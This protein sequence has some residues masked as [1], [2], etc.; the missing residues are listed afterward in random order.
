MP[1]VPCV[2]AVHVVLRC[3]MPASLE[4]SRLLCPAVLCCLVCPLPCALCCAA[5]HS[6][7]PQMF[8][9]QVMSAYQYLSPG[10]IFHKETS[11]TYDAD[12]QRFQSFANTPCEGVHVL[13]GATHVAV[14]FA[15]LGELAAAVC[16][17]GTTESGQLAAYP[18][19][20]DQGRPDAAAMQADVAASIQRFEQVA[21]ADGNSA[22]YDQRDL[23]ANNAHALLQ[24]LRGV[25]QVHAGSIPSTS[26]SNGDGSSWQQPVMSVPGQEGQPLR[27]VGYDASP[28]AVAKTAVLLEMMTQ[29][30]DTDAVLQVS[31]RLQCAAVCLEC[32]VAQDGSMLSIT[33]VVSC[34]AVHKR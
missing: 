5:C 12:Q 23:E 34:N 6:A 17:W 13:P 10:K 26:S 30:A 9:E 31:C 2:P 20:F 33:A 14:G 11:I 25:Q 32:Y 1:A 8:D 18:L 7:L 21:A 22:P 3:H 4:L 27:W 16:R 28:Y 29:N 15:D 19:E 24:V